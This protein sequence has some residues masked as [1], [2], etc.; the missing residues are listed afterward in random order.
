MTSP[1]E[2]SDGSLVLSSQETQFVPREDDEEILWKV[3]E[4]TSEKGDLYKVRWEGNDPETGKPWPQSWVPKHD[5]TNDLVRAW[6]R[7]KAMKKFEADQKRGESS[8][9]YNRT[10][11][12]IFSFHS[13]SQEQ[14]TSQC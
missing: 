3:I 13:C 2:D 11:L 1:D 14:R 7:A 12:D 4:I 9:C 5:C 6:K 8:S 10:A